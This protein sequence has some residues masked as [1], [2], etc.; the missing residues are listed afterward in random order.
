MA[1]DRSGFSRRSE[2]IREEWNGL[3]VG[4]NLWEARQPQD[5]V[6]GVADDQTVPVARPQPPAVFSGP[7]SIGLS[8][9]A[10][11][12]ATFLSLEAIN[13]F[14]AGDNVGVIL[15]DGSIFNT[16][17]VGA[18]LATGITIA[19]A[20]PLTAAAGNLVFDYEATGP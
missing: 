17:V 20:L 11:I 9:A 18:P 1:D 7:I 12:G 3:R 4:K 19:K 5:F 6:R 14:S 8:A 13:G 2:D 10:A 16:A 15:D